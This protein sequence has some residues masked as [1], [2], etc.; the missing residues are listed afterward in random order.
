[1][2]V[3]ELQTLRKTELASKKDELLKEL[4][5]NNAQVALGTTPQNPGKLRAIKKTIARINTFMIKN[6]SKELKSKKEV[7]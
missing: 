4:M 3:K 7:V 6:K 5:K 1:M 2:K